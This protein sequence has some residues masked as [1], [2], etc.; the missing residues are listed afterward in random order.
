M[1]QGRIDLIAA[2]LTHYR[3]R[4]ALIDFSI[5]YFQ[6]PQAF[7]VKKGRGVG[8]LSDLTRLHAG[9]AEGSAGAENFPTIHPG[10]TVKTFP[11]HPP[12]FESLQKDAIDAFV[13]DWV[14]LASM[15]SYAPNCDEL[16]ILFK[17]VRL[18]GGHYGI[19]IRENDSRWRD[20]IN[21]ILQDIWKDGSW[22]QLFNKWFGPT[23]PLNLQKEELFFQMPLWS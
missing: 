4:D 14:I 23:T 9:A 6:S 12:V 15:R 11:T 8:C 1:I 3:R 7:M 17:E 10:K 18:G 19:G 5:G 20:T 13:S 16:D 22:D 21:T 2:T